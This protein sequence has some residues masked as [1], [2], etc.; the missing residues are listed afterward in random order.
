ML[1]DIA[2]FLHFWSM[3]IDLI[4]YSIV[5]AG[6][7]YVTIHNRKLP[8]WHLTPLWYLGLASFFVSSTIL[9]EYIFGMNFPLSFTNV[10]IIGEKLT[11]MSLAFICLSMFLGTVIADIRN[12]RKRK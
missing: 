2:T 1:F 12:K 6:T 3:P 5:F 11:H 7:F 4:C 8:V 9:L 10:G